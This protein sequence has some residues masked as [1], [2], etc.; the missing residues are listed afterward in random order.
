MN[1]NATFRHHDT[2]VLSVTAVDAPV[3]KTSDDFDEVL[4][5]SY[6]RN[7]LRPGMLAALAGIRERRWWRE[8]QHFVDG[9][10]EAARLALEQASIDPSRVGLL[11]NTSVSRSHLEP[12]IAVDVHARLGLPS[13]CLNFDLT[14]ACLGFVNGMQLAATMIDAG[15]IDYALVVDG[16]GSREP[17]ENTLARLV[18]EETTARDLLDQFATLTLGSGAAAMVLG[19][20]SEHPEGHRVVGGVSRAATEHHDLCVGD[21]TEMRTD[22]QGLLT[23]GVQLARELW[24]EARGEFSWDDMDRYVVHQVSSVHTAKTA[25]ALGIDQSRIPLTFP[26]LGNVGPA[27]VA[28]TLAKEADSLRP[29]DR[30]LMMGVGSGLN[31]SCLELTW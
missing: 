16:E 14:N 13:S 27:A 4:A 17:Q 10:A 5:D 19:R 2:A 23:A 20:A 7:G 25:E 11:V 22:S 21:F 29:G 26:T 1:G 6:R 18:G 12:S 30:V 15:Q 28:I 24:E 31:M 3:V 9:T 8:D